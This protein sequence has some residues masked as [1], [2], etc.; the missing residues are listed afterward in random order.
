[1]HML[2]CNTDCPIKGSAHVFLILNKHNILRMELYWHIQKSE[3]MQPGKLQLLVKRLKDTKC[4][5]F[6]IKSQTTHIWEK[7]LPSSKIEKGC[8]CP[9]DH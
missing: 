7:K 8:I 5:L 4:D 9:T 1:M 6:N 2:D 3:W